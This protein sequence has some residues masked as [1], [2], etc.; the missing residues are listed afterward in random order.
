MTSLPKRWQVELEAQ[1]KLRVRIK[2]TERV[3][4]DLCKERVRILKVGGPKWPT[5][6]AKV[7]VRIAKTWDMVRVLLLKLYSR[8]NVV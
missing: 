2:E 7:N 6:L 1:R 5:A 8:P 3:H 4:S